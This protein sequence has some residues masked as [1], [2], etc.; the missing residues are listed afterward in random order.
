MFPPVYCHLNIQVAVFLSQS[1]IEKKKITGKIATISVSL[2]QSI[3][4]DKKMGDQIF[5]A[6]VTVIGAAFFINGIY[7]LIKGETKVYFGRRNRT[8]ATLTGTAGDVVAGMSVLSGAALLIASI[9]Y[10][11]GVISFDIG[12]IVA[13]AGVLLYQAV[14]FVMNLLK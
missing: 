9:T 12:F 10:W 3:K 2:T 7:S 11:L 4:E 14:A 6:V 8:L 1:Q 5:M 13:V